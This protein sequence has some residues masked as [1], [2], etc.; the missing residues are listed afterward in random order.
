MR[1]VTQ[2]PGPVE[3]GPTVPFAAWLAVQAGVVRMQGTPAAAWL[4][5][6]IDEMGAAARYVGATSPVELEDR[7]AVLEG[8]RDERF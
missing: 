3:A 7:L 1:S 8:I 6:K 2:I 5:G 4:A